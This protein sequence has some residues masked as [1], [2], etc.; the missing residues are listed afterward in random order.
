MKNNTL[1]KYKYKTEPFNHQRDALTHCFDKEFFA[2][3]MEMGTGKS[4]VLIDNIACLYLD[5][6][7]KK[8]AL[9]EKIFFAHKKLAKH[10]RTWIKK[11]PNLRAFQSADTAKN[12]ILE[13]LSY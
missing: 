6:K 8:D 2:L 11:I 7:I 12:E 3:F 13:Y 4:K 9:I 10:Q 1:V 5:N